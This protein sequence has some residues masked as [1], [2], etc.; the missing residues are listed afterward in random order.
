MVLWRKTMKITK[1][2]RERIIKSAIKKIKSGEEN[3]L[4][5]A[6]GD[7]I[8]EIIPESELVYGEE[9]IR[10]YLPKFKNEIALKHFNA[11]GH[12]LWWYSDDK[13]NPLAFLN[14]LLTGKLPKKASKSAR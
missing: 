1:K 11:I 10:Q 3:Y 4:C 13:K 9:A 8:G 2:Q 12:T 14:Y 6:L 5:Y 7:S